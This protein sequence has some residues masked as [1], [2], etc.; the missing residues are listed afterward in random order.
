MKYIVS[1]TTSPKRLLKCESMLKSILNQ[2]LKPDFIILNI[3]KIFSRTNEAYIIPKF[4]KQHVVINIIEKDLGPASKIVPTIKYLNINNFDKNNTR[5]IYLDDDI[6][7]MPGMIE[8]FDKYCKKDNKLILTGSGFR[9]IKQSP[10]G[11]RTHGSFVSIVEGYGGVCVSLSVF[12]NDFENYIE[13][14]LKYKACKFSDDVIL[15]NYYLIKKATLRSVNVTNKF[16]IP[17]MFENGSILAYGNE[18]DALH[19]GADNTILTNNDRYKDVI[20]ILKD[21]NDIHFKLY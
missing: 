15:S 8:C 18:K 2:T 11:F 9:F 21:N 12:E 19:E 6:K 5:I 4:V 13:K 1:F 14:Y 16:S 17:Y 3:P 7:Y 10:I 20:K